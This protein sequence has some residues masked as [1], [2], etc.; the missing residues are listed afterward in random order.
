MTPPKVHVIARTDRRFL[1]LVCKNHPGGPRSKSSGTKN[2]REAER[3]AALWEKELRQ[4]VEVDPHRTTFAAAFLAYVEGHISGLKHSSRDKPI[5]HIELFADVQKPRVL[6]DI[7]AQSLSRHATW[8]RRTPYTVGSKSKIRT[9]TT[10]DGHFRSIG[11]FLAWCKE[12][13]YIHE[14]PARPRFSRSRNRGKG[15]RMKGRPLTAHEFGQYLKAIPKVRPK[16]HRAFSR[17][18]R[19]LWLGGLRLE[20][21]LILSWDR[22][23]PFSLDL[24]GEHP[25]FWIDAES[26]KGFRDRMLPTAPEF[27]QWILKTPESDRKGLV[28]KLPVNHRSKGENASGWTVNRVSKILTAIGKASGVT[29]NTDGKPA[30]AHDFRR[31]FCL[32]WAEKIMPKDLMILARHENIAT[33]MS[34][35]VGRDATRTA[36]MLWRIHRGDSLGDTTKP[37]EKQ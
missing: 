26:E 6:A 21:S 17:L 13:R 24:S 25:L 16:S 7:T 11:G 19:G 37:S 29:V 1:Q 10:I 31:S 12:Q 30:S 2:R 27:A 23:T 4:Q 5:A 15:G 32:R 3:L 18:A 20:E 14:V 35:Y 34:Y 22:S 9:E 28:F 33:T 36:A 8:L